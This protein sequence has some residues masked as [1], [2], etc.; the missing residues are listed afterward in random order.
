MECREKVSLQQLPSVYLMT[1]E[2]RM[3]MAD[4]PVVTLFDVNG[5]HRQQ[6]LAPVFSCFPIF[7]IISENETAECYKESIRSDLTKR[8]HLHADLVSVPEVFI[9]IYINVAHVT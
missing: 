4:L 5:L 7:R 3:K 2:Q 9:Q 8:Y 6:A 1:T